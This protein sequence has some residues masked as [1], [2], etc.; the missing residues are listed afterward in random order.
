[1]GR[2]VQMP[3]LKADGSEI[4]GGVLNRRD[5]PIRATHRFS[6][7][8]SGISRT[9][10]GPSGETAHLAAIVKS[11]DDAIMSKNLQGMVTTWNQGG[12]ILWLSSR[13]DDRTARDP[14]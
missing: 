2:R 9:V 11:S 12:T 4:P 13:G 3:A 7:P 5:S 10:N 1:M 8:T 14:Q 6:P